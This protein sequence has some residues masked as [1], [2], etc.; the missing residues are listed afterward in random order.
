[1]RRDI[2]QGEVI[3]AKGPEQRED[4]GRGRCEDQQERALCDS[5]PVGATPDAGKETRSNPDQ[6][7][8]EA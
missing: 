2:T 5:R 8:Q 6:R 1:M 3:R 4:C 7:E